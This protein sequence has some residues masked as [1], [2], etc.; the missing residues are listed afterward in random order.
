MLGKLKKSLLGS[1]NRYSG[2]TDFLEAI[3]AANAL[4]IY[5]DGNVDDIELEAAMKSIEANPT[6]QSCFNSRQVTQMMDKMLKRA[7]GGRVGRMG[8]YNEIEDVAKDPDMSQAVMLAALD[9][10]DNDGISPEEEEV[11]KKISSK[12]NVN[13]DALMDV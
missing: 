8:L 11:L 3:C 6:L 2:N 7:E 10:A 5:A 1:V 9:V 4:V 13:M 12:L